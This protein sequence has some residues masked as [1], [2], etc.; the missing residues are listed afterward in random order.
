MSEPK[1]HDCSREA[2]VTRGGYQSCMVASMVRRRRVRTV[3]DLA[4]GPIG[5]AHLH[6][7]GLSGLPGTADRT[8]QKVTDRSPRGDGERHGRATGRSSYGR[9]PW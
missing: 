9:S 2:A 1:P 5:K 4:R 7:L 3:S 8:S 6:D